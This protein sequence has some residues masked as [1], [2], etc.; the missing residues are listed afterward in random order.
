MCKISEYARVPSLRSHLSL[1]HEHIFW[2]L[3]YMIIKSSTVVQGHVIK[4][5]P[6]WGEGRGEGEGTRD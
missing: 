1:S 2:R 6:K 5:R 4:L 3:Q